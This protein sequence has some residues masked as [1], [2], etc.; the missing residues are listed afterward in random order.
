M[1]SAANLKTAQFSPNKNNFKK[2]SLSAINDIL[3]N[4]NPASKD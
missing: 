3:N 1:V 2:W 4:I